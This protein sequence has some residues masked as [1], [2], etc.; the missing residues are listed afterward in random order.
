MEK[1]LHVQAEALTKWHKAGKLRVVRNGNTLYY[2]K[3]DLLALVARGD[4]S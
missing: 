2:R 3:E 1:G 4:M